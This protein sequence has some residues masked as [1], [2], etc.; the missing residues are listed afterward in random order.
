MS[1]GEY[2]DGRQPSILQDKWNSAAYIA[3]VM[4]QKQVRMAVELTR[5]MPAGT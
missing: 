4:T 5:L 3:K 2:L 1:E